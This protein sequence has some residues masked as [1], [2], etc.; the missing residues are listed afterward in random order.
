[1]LVDLYS[2]KPLPFYEKYYANPVTGIPEKS[3]IYYWVYWPKMGKNIT[4]SGLEKRLLQY[5]RNNFLFA[6]KVK[7]QYK[8][9]GMISEQWYKDN[10]NIFGLSEAKK[11]TLIDY[12][13]DDRQNVQFFLE[14]FKR[15]CFSRP[16]YIGKANNL[17]KRLVEQHFKSATEILPHIKASKVSRSDIYVGYELV[18]DTASERVNVIFEEIF[19]RKTKP[20]LT[21]KP[22]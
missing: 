4:V 16:F 11:N 6:E 20:G 19:S 1:M 22:N 14:F 10:G 9:E 2:F 5:S 3:G 21:K 13:N 8:F 18:N 7:G 12:L 17:R 15:V